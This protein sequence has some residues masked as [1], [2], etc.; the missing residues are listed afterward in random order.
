MAEFERA[1][2]TAHF[3][4]FRKALDTRDLAAM[5]EMFAPDAT[6]GNSVYG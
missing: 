1:E 3:E 4:R 2:V 5:A 6:G